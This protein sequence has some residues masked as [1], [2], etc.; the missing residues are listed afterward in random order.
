LEHENM[1]QKR[2]DTLNSLAVV[3][4]M[5]LTSAVAY[6]QVDTGTISGAVRDRSGAIIPNAEVII[7]NA[8]TG[9][10]Q[11]L[12]TNSDGLYVSLPLYAGQYD[13]E[14][15]A[16]GFKKETQRLTL[17]EPFNSE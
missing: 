17:N 1:P 3:L 10:V 11:H 8:G 2:S 14:V 13:L 6:G 4:L 12:T 7:R 15:E 16:R 9:Q 5:T